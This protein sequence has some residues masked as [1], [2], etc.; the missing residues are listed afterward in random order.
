MSPVS[1]TPK[2]RWRLRDPY[3]RQNGIPNFPP[4]VA[5][6]LASRGITTRAQADIFYKPHLVPDH[7]PLTMPDMRRAV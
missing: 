3:A 2:A 1:G 7:D 5:T 6:V 4:I